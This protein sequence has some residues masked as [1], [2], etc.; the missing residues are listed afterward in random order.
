MT[1]FMCGEFTA[2]LGTHTVVRNP[3]LK[4]FFIAQDL[5]RCISIFVRLLI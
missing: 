5:Q 1:F 2:K 4:E 3:W